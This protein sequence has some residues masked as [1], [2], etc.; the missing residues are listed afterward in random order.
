MR[1]KYKRKPATIWQISYYNA[2]QRCQNP[3]CPDYKN[4][5]GRGIKLLMSSKDFQKLWVRDNAEIMRKPSI[6]RKDNDGN[7]TFENCR[8]IE[9]RD[10]VRRETIG[11]KFDESHKKNLSISQQ[12][13]RNRERNL[14]VKAIGRR[15]GR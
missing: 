12:I 11:K 1:T 2:Q 3:K 7:Y 8:F 4:Y 14:M 6:D 9:L 5:G 15:S 10:N 13:R